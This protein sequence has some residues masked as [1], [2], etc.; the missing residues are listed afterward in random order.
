MVA[1]VVTEVGVERRHADGR[2]IGVIVGK[3]G[4]GEEGRPI[5]LLVIAKCADVLFNCLVDPLGLAIGLGV[6]SCGEVWANFK[7]AKNLT[8]PG[9]G[10][11]GSPVGG[12][13]VGETVRTEDVL[14]EEGGEG[15]GGIGFVSWNK[16]GHL[17]EAVD[18]YED[19]VELAVG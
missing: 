4:N 18:Y 19:T 6:E 12:D 2:V 10:E 15:W 11:R 3:F 1:G 9:G 17:G 13:I 14:Y 16:M 7:L 8:P 5:C